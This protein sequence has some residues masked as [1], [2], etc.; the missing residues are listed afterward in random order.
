VPQQQ[1]LYRDAAY[2]TGTATFAV[3]VVPGA[4]VNARA[5]VGDAYT[6]WAGITLQMEGGPLVSADT[7]ANPF[8]SYLLTGSDANNDGVVTISI[9]N[10]TNPW[11]LNGLDIRA[12]ADGALPP[13]IGP[14][15]APQLAAEGAARAGAAAT[16]TAEQV[17]PIFAEA[18]RRWEATGLSVSQRALLRSATFEIG[19][20]GMGG[21]LG[22]TSLGGNLVRL[23]DDGAGRGWFVDAT[24]GDDA[25][26]ASA[27]GL[28]QLS[29]TDRGAARGYDLLTVVMHELGHT[30]GLDSVDASVSPHDLLTATLPLGVRRLPTPSA[31]PVKLWVS[32]ESRATAGTWDT[33]VAR[34]APR[35]ATAMESSRTVATMD[36]PVLASATPP[37]TEA[38]P[39]DDAWTLGGIAV[40]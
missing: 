22:L 32:E 9:H 34:S 37:A 21:H 14:G 7:A 38:A 17:A 13:S 20:L 26:F 27:F 25:E 4:A 5:Y 15:A 24:P 28:T 12:A 35:P 2:G 18:V 16:L 6:N 11:V 29:A 39:D 23:D 19:D 10:A 30:L 8:W 33:P 31:A 1:P 36:L 3:G 40:S